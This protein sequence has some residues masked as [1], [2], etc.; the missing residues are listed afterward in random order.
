MCGN[1]GNQPWPR[2]SGK[3]TPAQLAWEKCQQ[4]GKIGRYAQ[5]SCE[6]AVAVDLRH[7]AGDVDGGAAERQDRQGAAVLRRPSVHPRNPLPRRRHARHRGARRRFRAVLRHPPERLRHPLDRAGLFAQRHRGAERPALL[8]HPV[9]H[10]PAAALRLH[11]ELVP[12]PRSGQRRH[13]AGRNRRS[14]QRLRHRSHRRDSRYQRLLRLTVGE[15][16]AAFLSR[17]ALPRGRHARF[18]GPLRRAFDDHRTEPRFCGPRQRLRHSVERQRLLD[19][20]DGGSARLPGLF[21]S[22][23]DRSIAAQRLD[24]QFLAGESRGQRGPGSGR[25]Q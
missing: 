8:S 10:R 1:R 24:P 11:A 14:R 18:S 22:V 20:R 17:P 4:G 15:R 16:L 12:G 19:E 6:P 2:R 9:A 13:R 23:A 25:S 3:L 7:G 21:D 5:E